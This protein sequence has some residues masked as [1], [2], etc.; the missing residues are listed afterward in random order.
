M[1]GSEYTVG[2]EIAHAATHGVG[3]LLSLAGLFAL[4]SLAS[5]R[6]ELH[7]VIGCSIFGI[8]LVVLYA[9][10]TLYHSTRHPR[11]KKLLQRF[12]HAAILLLIAGTYTPFMLV[13]MRGLWGSALLGVVWGLALIGIG[14]QTALP[15][16]MTVVSVVLSLAMGWMIVSALEPL[17][18]A[19]EPAGM[20]LLVAGGLS[21]T[22]GVVFFMWERMPFNHAVWHLFVMAGSIFHYACVVGYVI[23]AAA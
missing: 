16:R 9:S 17:T 8:T 6:G 13:S 14:L 19:I 1:V 12:D 15:A 23:P 5:S 11:V 22:A 18:A 3:L 7:H 10:S 20:Q 2:E 4:V 21:Y